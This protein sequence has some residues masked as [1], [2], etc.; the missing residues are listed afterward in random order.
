MLSSQFQEIKNNLNT[1]KKPHLS[2]E[3]QLENLKKNGLTVPNS[4]Y[5][6]KKLSHINYYRLS[7]YFLTFQYP[8]QST[9][10][11]QFYP[12]SEFRHIIR[13]Y[14]FDVKFRRLLFGAMETI[15][16]YVRTQIAYHHSAEYEAFGYLSNT[17][18][19]CNANVFEEL[20]EDIKNESKRSDEKFIKHFKDKYGTTDLPIWSLVEVLSFGTLSKIFYAMHNDDKKRVIEQIPVTTTVF[21][22]WLHSFTILRNICAHHSRAW[23][24]ELRVPFAIPSKNSM[25][26][27]LRKITKSKFKEEVDGALIYEKKEY[28]NNNSIFFSLSVIKYIF[29][30]I[31]EEVNFI[32]EIKQLLSVYPELDLKAMGF[33]DNWEKLDIWSDV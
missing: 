6:L 15:E 1:Y 23:N 18:F 27:P 31:G 13:L 8:K 7:S 21:S 20:I 3:K 17:N 22:K 4:S 10:V 28:D 19:Q 33:I 2:F 25:F 30:N 16:V 11:N 9:K 29:D 5:S 12:K 14:E 24:R 26:D 32:T